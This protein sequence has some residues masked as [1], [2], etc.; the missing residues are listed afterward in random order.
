MSTIKLCFYGI[1]I[2]VKV[3]RINFVHSMSKMDEDLKLAF[4]LT[5]CK[6]R[7]RGQGRILIQN[8]L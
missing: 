7:E 2:K 5:F 1:Y 6:Y 4:S 8:F 3:N